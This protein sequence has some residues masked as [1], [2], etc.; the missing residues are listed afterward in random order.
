MDKESNNFN[1]G[2]ELH[3]C[4]QNYKS[5]HLHAY[6]MLM[7]KFSN[8][9][10]II[11]YTIVVSYNLCSAYT[12]EIFFRTLS[13]EIKFPLV[14]QLYATLFEHPWLGSTN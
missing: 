8:V 14:M 10:I 9:R 6:I 13:C 5:L 1:P 12:A 2:T 3:T 4:G 11:H 7:Y